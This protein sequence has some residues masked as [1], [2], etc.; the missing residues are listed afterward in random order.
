MKPKIIID[1]SIVVETVVR[2]DTEKPEE[3]DE[4]VRMLVDLL[5][6]LKSLVEGR[7]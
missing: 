5:N 6:D 1:L 3:I 4:Q 2:L 7:T